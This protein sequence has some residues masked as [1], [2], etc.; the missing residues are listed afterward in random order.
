LGS[1][2]HWSRKKLRG[3]H[4]WYAGYP[5]LIKY[6]LQYDGHRIKNL[7]ELD[8]RIGDLTSQIEGNIKEVDA[9]DQGLHNTETFVTDTIRKLIFEGRYRLLSRRQTITSELLL[10]QQARDEWINMQKAETAHRAY[11]AREA[12]T[13]V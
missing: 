6:S 1:H 8:D 13:D 10:V 4:L 5:A 11:L 2:R 3:A 12:V 7:Q 9:I